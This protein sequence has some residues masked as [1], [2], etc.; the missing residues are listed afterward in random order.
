MLAFLYG[1]NKAT[2]DHPCIWCE[3]NVKTDS[4]NPGKEW[5]ISRRLENTKTYKGSIADPI[6]DFID[7]DYCVVDMLHLLLRISDCLFCELLRILKDL[8][9]TYSNELADNIHLKKFFDFIEKICNINFFYYFKNGKWELR[10]FNSVELKKIFALLF[11][12]KDLFTV[13]EIDSVILKTENLSVYNRLLSYNYLLK[14]FYKLYT[15]AKNDYDL[16]TIDMF[17]QRLKK[18]IF[19]FSNSG[20]FNSEKF[21]PY[22][23]IFSHHL[24]QMIQLHTNVNL[25]TCQGLEKLNERIKNV[26]KFNTNKQREKYQL[27]ILNHINRN[28]LY[29]D[30]DFNVN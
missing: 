16:E 19:I 27:Q 1:I 18:W 28:E 10:S 29:G 5:T 17:K 24:P 2:A 3:F 11:D 14:E 8:D 20:S 12:D 30:D 4:L 22:I 13:L 23:H 25:F 21:T 9:N 15:D 26:F 6:I 7:Y